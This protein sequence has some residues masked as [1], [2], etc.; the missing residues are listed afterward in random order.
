MI[1]AIVY[2][3]INPHGMQYN[4]IVGAPSVQSDNGPGEMVPCHSGNNY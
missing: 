1:S 4:F 2:Y 3:K